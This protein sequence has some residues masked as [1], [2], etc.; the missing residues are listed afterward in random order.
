MQ[1][2]KNCSKHQWSHVLLTDESMLMVI[3]ASKNDYIWNESWTQN[4]NVI[5][6]TSLEHHRFGN[7]GMIV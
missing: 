5:Y 2:P 7:V 3:S 1:K 4:D 6:G